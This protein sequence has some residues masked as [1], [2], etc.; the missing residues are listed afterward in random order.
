LST[1]KEVAQ[2]AGVS[3]AT[4]SRVINK[5]PAVRPATRDK[6]MNAIAQ[7][8]YTPNLLGRHLRQTRT[9]KILVLIPSISNQ[10]YSKIIRAMEKVWKNKGMMYLCV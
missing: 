7:L 6:V 5:D 2:S 9:N 1:I 4:V 3:V 8:S 10:F